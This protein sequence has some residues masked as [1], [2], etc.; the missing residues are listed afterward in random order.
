MYT[1][2]FYETRDGQCPV[3]E[4]LE[5]LRIKSASNKDARIQ[6]NRPFYTL[7]YFS[8]MVLVSMIISPSILKMVF[9]NCARATI[10]YFTF[11]MKTTHL[12]YSTSSV[13]NHKKHQN[14]K[15]K[16]QKTNES[17]TLAER[18]MTNHENME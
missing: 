6:H 15:L 10:V 5:N 1:V 4:F 11:F 8:K 18:S 12:Y 3:W 9:G 14:V 2:E 7:N 13:K 16:K 17:I